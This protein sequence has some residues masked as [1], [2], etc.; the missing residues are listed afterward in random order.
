MARRGACGADLSENIFTTK[1]LTHKKESHGHHFRNTAVIPHTSS[2]CSEDDQVL[3]SYV[4]RNN[5]KKRVF[6]L[7]KEAIV[8]V[9]C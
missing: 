4:Y 1:K 6:F 8:T 5:L 9:F 3:L 7:G 2:E